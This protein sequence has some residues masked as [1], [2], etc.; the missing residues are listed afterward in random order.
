MA[1]INFD[2]GKLDGFS[3]YRPGG[4]VSILTPFIPG[5][6][7]V[8]GLIAV[9]ENMPTHQLTF[10]EFGYY[11][12]IPIIVFSM[13]VVG[14]VLAV[15]MNISSYLVAA[16]L[17][18]WVK[19]SPHFNIEPWKNREWRKV[20][21]QFIGEELAPDVQDPYNEDTFQ[22]YLEETNKIEDP[23]SRAKRLEW[24]ASYFPPLQIA[25]FEW[26][27][28]YWI[29]RDH[30][31]KEDTAH[32]VGFQFTNVVHSTGWVVII[33]L[34]FTPASDFFTTAGNSLLWITTILALIV[35]HLAILSQVYYQ[36]D[37]LGTQLAA[38]ILRT[39][40]SRSESDRAD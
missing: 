28:W 9:Y 40:Q 31:P 34:S 1:L 3:L 26:Y 2:L 27:S 29:L 37:P 12:E 8:L 5:G 16:V 13:Y 17:Y 20:A 25:D 7:L 21:K 18:E 23:E 4:V 11:S 14:F 6:T 36:K 22:Q 33:L 39:L 19:G 10:P 24:I 35:G 15:F 38:D 30:F 32:L